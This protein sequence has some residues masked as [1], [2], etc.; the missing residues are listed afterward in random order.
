MSHDV[1][2][3][4]RLSRD[5]LAGAEHVLL[6]GDP[7]RVEKT[8]RHLGADATFL[9]ANREYTSWLATVAARKVLVCSTGIGG[10]SLSIAVEE[11]ASLGLK[12]FIRIGTTGAIQPDIALPCVIISTGCVRLDGASTHYAPIEY[13]AVANLDLT[14]ALV[15]AAKELGLNYRVGITASADT[16]YPGQE[17]YDT[18]S[19]YVPRHFR[20]SLEEWQRLKV[21]NYEMEG[22]TLFTIV[23]TFGLRAAMV[24]S[25]IVSRCHGET[26]DDAAL[27]LAEENL[28][29][30]ARRALELDITSG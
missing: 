4:V 14:N 7:G 24:A 21:L 2:Y 20:G 25:A 18:F 9:A 19:G 11:L 15:S 5:M 30:V 6:P 17:R 3:H 1:K 26:P 8:A 12:S 28:A 16:F 13:P 22:A 23:S 27:A 10:P 29:K